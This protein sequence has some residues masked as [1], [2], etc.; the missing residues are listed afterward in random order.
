MGF[1]SLQDL[2]ESEDSDAGQHQE[3]AEE[4]L[5]VDWSSGTAFPARNL[6]SGFNQYIAKR[7]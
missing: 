7:L 5:G 4:N 3:L 1:N 2:T 6:K